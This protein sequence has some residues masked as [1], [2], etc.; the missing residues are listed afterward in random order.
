MAISAATDETAARFFAAIERE[1]LL[2]DP[3]FAASELRLAHKEELQRRGSRRSGVSRGR[4][5]SLLRLRT[6]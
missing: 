4:R 3:R 1:E 2:A 6:G 5:F